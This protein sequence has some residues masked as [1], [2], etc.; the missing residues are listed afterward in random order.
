MN[1]GALTSSQ[2][3]AFIYAHDPSVKLKKL[4]PKHKV[5]IIDVQE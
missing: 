5:T 4:T 2:L 3:A 1:S